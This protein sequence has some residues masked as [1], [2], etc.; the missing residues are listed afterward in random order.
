MYFEAIHKDVPMNILFYFLKSGADFT[1][2]DEV[3]IRDGE[4]V[5]GGGR[6]R[7]EERE[8]YH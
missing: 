4:G 5:G 1:L 2:K 7:G 3:R 8:A 6:D